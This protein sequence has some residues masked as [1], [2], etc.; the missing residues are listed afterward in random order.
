MGLEPHDKRFLRIVIEKFNGGPVGVN[1]LA[2]ALNEDRRVLEDIY[3]PYLMKL[4]FLNRTSAGR[5][6]TPA[7]YEHLGLKNEAKL[8]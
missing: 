5:V 2:A 6:I 1:T 4:G 3:E 8:L 7:A